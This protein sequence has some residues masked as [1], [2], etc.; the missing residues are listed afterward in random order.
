VYHSPTGLSSIIF[1]WKSFRVSDLAC[2]SE[3]TRISKRFLYFLFFCYINYYAG[4]DDS[5]LILQSY[6]SS[7][8]KQFKLQLRA[9]LIALAVGTNI[10]IGFGMGTEEDSPAGWMP[11]GR[12]F[13]VGDFA[14]GSWGR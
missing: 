8:T 13:G 5:L 10:E 14:H 9:F 3:L 1:A 11:F 4:S 12:G 7:P 2:V 6:V